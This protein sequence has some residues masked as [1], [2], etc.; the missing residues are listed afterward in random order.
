[1]K[2]ARAAAAAFLLI[3]M[4]AC[5]L[6]PLLVPASYAEQFREIPNASCSRQHLLGKTTWGAIAS[7]ACSMDPAFPFSWRRLLPYWPLHL[8]GSRRCGGTGRRLD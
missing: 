7:L 1:M 4:A 6:G 2:R 5:L 8:Q 3:V